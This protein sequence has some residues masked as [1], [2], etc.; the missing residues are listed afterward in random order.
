MYGLINKSIEELVVANFGEEKW[1]E[2]KEHSNVDIDFF[3]SSEQYDDSVTFSLAGSIAEVM[4][5]DIKDVL[6]LF[7]EWWIIDTTNKKYGTMIHSSGTNLKDF[8]TS[9][10]NFHNRVMM[11]YPKITPPEFQVT[12]IT[13]DSLH[14]HY[15]SKRDGLQEFVRGLLQGLSKLFKQ[16][17]KI[18]LIKSRNEGSDHEVFKVN[19]L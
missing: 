6:I 13:E 11:M 17:T 5:I 12:D 4:N 16:E 8:L 9:L 18:E 3:L 1:E 14:V 19:L 7:G 10:P 2:I 15:Y